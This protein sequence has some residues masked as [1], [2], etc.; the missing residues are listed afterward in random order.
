MFFRWVETTNQISNF[1]LEDPIFVIMF[2]PFIPEE[3]A[4]LFSAMN[5]KQVVRSQVMSVLTGFFLTPKM[6]DSTLL[7]EC[8][9]T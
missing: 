3:Q 2:D 1:A 7:L 9:T 4:D 6:Y 8:L 5:Q